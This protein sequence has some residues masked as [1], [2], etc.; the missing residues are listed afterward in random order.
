MAL[1]FPFHP[2]LSFKSIS[3]LHKN[4]NNAFPFIKEGARLSG[5]PDLVHYFFNHFPILFT[6]CLSTLASHVILMISNVLRKQEEKKL[7]RRIY[8]GLKVGI[9]RKNTANKKVFFKGKY[10]KL[11]FE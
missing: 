10:Y 9:D 2:L 4:K 6:P 11:D 1:S 7:V 3:L 5:L 8:E